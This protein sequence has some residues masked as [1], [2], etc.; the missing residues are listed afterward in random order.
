MIATSGNLKRKLPK[1]T[2]SK[3]EEGKSVDII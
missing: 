1:C 2:F 3:F